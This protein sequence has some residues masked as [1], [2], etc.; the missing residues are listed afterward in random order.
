[1]QAKKHTAKPVRKTDYT[2][3]AQQRIVQLILLMFSDVVLGIAPS[4][5]AKALQCTASTIT[6]DLDNLA[7]AGLAE[8]DEKTGL[9]RLTPRLPQQAIKV[10]TAIDNAERRIQE[11]RQRFSHNP[12]AQT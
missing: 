10:W 4:A 3:E 11:S 7:K 2:N 8:R 12:F 9:W 1:M 6:R 5:L